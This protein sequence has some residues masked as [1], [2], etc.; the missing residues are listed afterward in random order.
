MIGIFRPHI[1]TF[2][3]NARQMKVTSVFDKFK[4]EKERETAFFQFFLCIRGKKIKKWQPHQD[5]N[6]N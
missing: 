4:E 3:C 5:S 2:G 6:L 1:Q